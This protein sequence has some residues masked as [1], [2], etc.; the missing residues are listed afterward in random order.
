MEQT[1][2]TPHLTVLPVPALSNSE[3]PQNP[4]RRTL[5]LP[6]PAIPRYRLHPN[7]PIHHRRQR[8]LHTTPNHVPRK[9][10]TF[11]DKKRWYTPTSLL[12][13]VNPSPPTTPSINTQNSKQ[14]PEKI[15]S[16][17]KTSKTSQYPSTSTSDAENTNPKSTPT[18]TVTTSNSAE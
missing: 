1:K 9:Q 4:H 14:L 3:I 13:S 10:I 15:P 5:Y 12:T 6:N 18:Y 17:P 2:K 11:I 8:R 16:Y 7:I